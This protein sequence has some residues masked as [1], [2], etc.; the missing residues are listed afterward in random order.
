MKEA[1]ELYDQVL[2]L[3][4][5][6]YKAWFNRG[7]LQSQAG[8]DES[9][10]SDYER[11][12]NEFPDFATCHYNKGV[13]EN[14]LG[15]HQEALESFSSAIDLEQN[16]DFYHNRGFTYY[17]LGQID[18]A[19][20]DFTSALQ[21]DPRHI[22]ARFTRARCY[23]SLMRLDDALDDLVRCVQQSPDDPELNLETAL[24][25][26]RYGSKYLTSALTKFKK[27]FTVTQSF[28]KKAG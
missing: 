7:Y 2:K 3:N 14:N 18:K 17:S 28:G 11:S 1:I 16:A 8:N 25:E 20:K 27:L 26:L 13:S 19:V 21:M 9:A 4:P 6:N 5:T 23:D 15:R 22:K 10:V 12:L 24:L